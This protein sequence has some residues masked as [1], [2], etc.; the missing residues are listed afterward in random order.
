[1]DYY[2]LTAINRGDPVIL[3]KEFLSTIDKCGYYNL[4]VHIIKHKYSVVIG[5]SFKFDLYMLNLLK[6]YDPKPIEDGVVFSTGWTFKYTARILQYG[7][8]RF[9]EM[10]RDVAH[11]NMI[12]KL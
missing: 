9:G 1:M 10:E 7:G 12:F 3:A 6:Q 8:A 4:L 2:L 11:E 5:T